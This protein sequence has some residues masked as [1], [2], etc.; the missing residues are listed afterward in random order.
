MLYSQVV[1]MVKQKIKDF[2]DKYSP[3][4]SADFVTMALKVKRKLRSPN[5]VVVAGINSYLWL[6]DKIS[7]HQ[8]IL[9]TSLFLIY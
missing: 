9:Y 2:V 5:L 4:S 7:P 8:S 3:Y 6:A 1:K